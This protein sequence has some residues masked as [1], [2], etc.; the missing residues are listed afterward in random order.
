MQRELA[1]GTS[2]SLGRRQLQPGGQAASAEAVGLALPVPEREA[3]GRKTAGRKTAGRKTAGRR[4]GWL[5]VD[6]AEQCW[7]LQELLAAA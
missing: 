2:V 7:T 4:R 3:A 6:W 1:K 5:V